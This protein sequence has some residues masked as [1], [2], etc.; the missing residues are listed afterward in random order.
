MSLIF[1]S[2]QVHISRVKQRAGYTK[3]REEQTVK[4]K[5][6]KIECLLLKTFLPFNFNTVGNSCDEARYEDLLTTP[7]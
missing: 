5:P 4:L 7:L 1:F 3:H 2:R 6:I